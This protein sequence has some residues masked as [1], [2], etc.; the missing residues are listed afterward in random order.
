[1]SMS[2]ILGALGPAA[3][4]PAGAAGASAAGAGGLFSGMDLEGLGPIL[5]GLGGAVSPSDPAPIRS[6]GNPNIKAGA[7][8]IIP[9][10]LPQ[11]NPGSINLR[12]G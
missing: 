9:T 1:M 8:G 2:A 3:S 6:L 12:R 7:G 4:I 5:A 11:V 10:Q